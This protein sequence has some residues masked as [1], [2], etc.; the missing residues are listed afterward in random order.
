MSAHQQPENPDAARHL[1]EAMVRAGLRGPAA[2][3][4]D[5]LAPFDFLSTQAMMFVRPFTVGWRWEPYTR[6]LTEEVA[7]RELRRALSEAGGEKSR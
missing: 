3:V 6:A 2:F 7:W 4:L 5:I 1:A